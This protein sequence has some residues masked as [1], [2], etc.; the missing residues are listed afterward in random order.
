MRIADVTGVGPHFLR[1]TSRRQ[2]GRFAKASCN[3]ACRVAWRP[4]AAES[5]FPAVPDLLAVWEQ[6]AASATPIGQ[7]KV[8]IDIPWLTRD[9]LAY[10]EG[11]MD[12]DAM[13]VMPKVTIQ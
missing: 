9:R 4:K 10:K 1:A 8:V 12:S 11:A 2:T 5:A 6:P 7:D 13:D 3:A